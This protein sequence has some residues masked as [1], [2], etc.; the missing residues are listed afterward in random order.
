M[1]VPLILLPA[2]DV[3]DGRAVRLVQGRAG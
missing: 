2:V 1:S 3:V